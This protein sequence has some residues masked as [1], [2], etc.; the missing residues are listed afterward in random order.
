[1]V[2]ICDYNCNACEYHTNKKYKQG[3]IVLQLADS[4]KKK[5]HNMQNTDIKSKLLYQQEKL[6]FIN[7]VDR[8]VKS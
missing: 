2:I 7:H 3:L 6:K 5:K 8:L 1:M 4:L